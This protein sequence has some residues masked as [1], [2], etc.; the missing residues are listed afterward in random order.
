[1]LKKKAT[2]IFLILSVSC[3]I[4]RKEELVEIPNET[5]LEGQPI[6]I[7]GIGFPSLNMI[8]DN[9]I[10]MNRK[11]TSLFNIYETDNFSRLTSFGLLGNGPNEF[12][13]PTYGTKV[14]Q[15]G[16][17]NN[18]IS[19]H[20]LETN[21]TSSIELSNNPASAPTLVTKKIPNTDAGYVRKVVFETDSTLIFM[22]ENLGRLAFFNKNSGQ[23]KITPYIPETKNSVKDQNN[24]MVYQ[25]EIAVNLDKKLIAAAPI[26]LGELDFFDFSGQLVK[27]IIYDSTNH[28]S[29]ELSN[30]NVTKSELQLFT[31]DI[32]STVNSIF[33]LITDQ[34][35]TEVRNKSYRN[36]SRILELDW[37]GNYLNQY[38]IGN[39][40]KSFAY[41]EKK[42]AFY[43]YNIYDEENPLWVYR[44]K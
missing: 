33:L 28:N 36:Q 5:I 8:G 31:H 17:D 4:E 34:K 43:I 1:M 16:R 20:D 37:N 14:N 30:E 41:D 38:I 13:Q 35:F 3:T 23:T 27:T 6:P 26:L 32:Q 24:W 12:S 21:S 25:S 15:L 9:L 44:I 18:N 42:K 22:P 10:I 7:N 19:I 2:I 29:R 39:Y 40:S 11:D